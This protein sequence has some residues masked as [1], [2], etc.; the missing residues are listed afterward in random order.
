MDKTQIMTEDFIT[1][2]NNQDDG[3]VPGEEENQTT[4]YRED[5]VPD[6]KKYS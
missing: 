2:I 4:R 5:S 3:D 6:G 1:G